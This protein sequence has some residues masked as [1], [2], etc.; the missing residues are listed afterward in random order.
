MN[1]SRVEK[2]SMGEPSACRTSEAEANWLGSGETQRTKIP[3]AQI[4]AQIQIPATASA[5][6]LAAAA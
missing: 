2:D 3:P 1:D 5:T 4:D 6:S